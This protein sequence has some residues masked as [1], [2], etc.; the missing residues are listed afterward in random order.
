MLSLPI[1]ASDK[2]RESGYPCG[3]S[4]RVNE[5]D[6][7][8]LDVH[9]RNRRA[10]MTYIP[11]Q[12]VISPRR[13]ISSVEVIF[14]GGADGGDDSWA[15]AV[16]SWRDDDQSQPR[17]RVGLRW[18]GTAERP[19]GN[20]TSSGRPTWFMLPENAIADDALAHARQMARSL[21]QYSN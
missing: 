7:S 5:L 16:I 17:Q 8:T 12:D 6:A 10:A 21:S 18:N 11:P 13:N 2:R 1:E 15:L 20:P 9:N 4:E 19:M 14:D 3:A